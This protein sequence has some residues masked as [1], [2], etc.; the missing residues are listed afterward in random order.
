MEFKDGVIYVA[1]D[2]TAIQG[3]VFETAKEKI[4]NMWEVLKD[5][6]QQIVSGIRNAFE[7]LTGEIEQI[8]QQVKNEIKLRRSWCVPMNLKLSNQ[9]INRKPMFAYARSR[10]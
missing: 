7:K 6:V 1:P 3:N 8:N 5:S 10:L 2:G 9:V 4:L